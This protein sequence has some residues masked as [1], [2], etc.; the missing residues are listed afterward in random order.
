MNILHRL[1][2]KTLT[3][4]RTR[5]LVTIIGVIL[6]T[7]L[8]MAIATSISSLQ[9]LLVQRNIE[10]YGNWHARALNHD[11]SLTDELENDGT[12]SQ[13][14]TGK[15]IGYTKIDLEEND[16][17][18]YLN[19]VPG[20][21]F[22]EFPFEL[23]DGRFPENEREVIVSPRL[24]SEFDNLNIGDTI[25]L[26]IGIRENASGE[27][28]DIEGYV[29]DPI[30]ETFNAGTPS[31]YT[32]VG[33]VDSALFSAYDS[34]SAYTLYY[35]A[36]ADSSDHLF[37]YVTLNDPKDALDVAER[38]SDWAME[39]NRGLLMLMGVSGWDSFNQ[40]LFG[41]AAILIVLIMLGSILL[42]YN[43]FA[44]SI[45]QRTKQFG[46]LS[47]IGTTKKQLKKVIRREAFLIALIGIPLGIALGI[48]GIG[49]TFMVIGDALYSL[50]DGSV[51]LNVSWQAIVITVIIAIATVVIS[52]T[53]PARRAAK[54]VPLDAIRQSTD[55]TIAPKKVKNSRITS[56]LF[57]FEGKLAEKNFKRNKKQYRS[58][59]VSLV[60]SVVL[61]ISAGAFTMYLQAG[62]AQSVFVNNSDMSYATQNSADIEKMLPV[63]EKLDEV[64]DI[65][66]HWSTTAQVDLSEDQVNPFYQ[67][68][69]DQDEWSD[70]LFDIVFL[71]QASYEKFAAEI[72]HPNARSI[73][74]NNFVFRDF[75]SGKTYEGPV[76]ENLP[77]ELRFFTDEAS[78]TV[79]LDAETTEIPLGGNREGTPVVILP[80]SEGDAFRDAGFEDV[81]MHYISM[82]SDNPSELET[83]MKKAFESNG[84]YDYYLMNH[85]ADEQNYRNIILAINTFAYGFVVM[86]SPIAIANVFNTIST[87]V[88]LRKREF[89]MLKSVGMGQKAF[90]KMMSF[91]CVMYGT[92]ALLFG[93]PISVLFTAAIYVAMNSSSDLPFTLPWSS[94]VI[95]VCTVFLVVAASMI[96]AVSKTNKVSIVETIRN[97]NI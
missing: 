3:S 32:I 15:H 20:D 52:A 95:A 42:I 82:T 75:D 44:I 7:A 71:D 70:P 77:S 79:P 73:L 60:V 24:M 18:I 62:I 80:E 76:V 67:D 21:A 92:K 55:V 53:I 2:Q 13:I 34:Y 49:I 39:T 40:T 41:M 51:S 78:K 29:I 31:D 63:F 65:S 19:A 61:F 1:A 64:T 30:P 17:Y 81:Y 5:T 59:I 35:P 84:V 38:Y 28:W 33:V 97:E 68:Y 26:D 45:S 43:S 87:N 22:S 46:L 93:I 47:S 58:T 37:T 94:I 86:I 72:G 54:I 91:E 96:Y 36:S 83:K 56:K 74:I 89:A 12:I 11:Q 57:G 14:H 10:V 9:A 8:I 48:A 88:N 85:A 50:V 23:Q 25:S 16:Y 69:L 90:R 27:I 4:N 6:S 66:S